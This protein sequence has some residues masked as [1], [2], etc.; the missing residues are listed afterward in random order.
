MYGYW[1]RP[2]TTLIAGKIRL[3]PYLLYKKMP[4]FAIALRGLTNDEFKGLKSKVRRPKDPSPKYSATCAR[5]RTASGHSSRSRRG[6]HPRSACRRTSG[7]RRRN[8]TCHS[9]LSSEWRW[10]ARRRKQGRRC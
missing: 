7:G 1:I 10:D 8:T 3:I 4:R 2:P 9:C 5:Q 6:R